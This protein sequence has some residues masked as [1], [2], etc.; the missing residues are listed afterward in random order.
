[1]FK[2]NRTRVATAVVAASIATTTCVSGVM[3]VRL[4]APAP[5][6]MLQRVEVHQDTTPPQPGQVHR[7]DP[8]SDLGRMMT[9]MDI[10]EGQSFVKS[11]EKE[12]LPNKAGAAAVPAAIKEKIANMPTMSKEMLRSMMDRWERAFKARNGAA[13]YD[14]DLETLAVWRKVMDDGK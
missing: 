6:P 9:P 1:M 14:K 10:K 7:V 5:S 13:N 12:L 4:D 2:L 3:S 11:F 8:E